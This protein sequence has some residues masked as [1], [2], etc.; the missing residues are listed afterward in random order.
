MKRLLVAVV[1]G[2]FATRLAGAQPADRD[3][4]KR[5]FQ[6]GEQAYAAGQYE[7]AIRAYE[8]AHQ[9]LPL[10]AITFSVAQAYRLAYYQ[11]RETE[12]LRKA[13]DLYQRYLDDAP[14]G[15]RRV[16]ATQ[17]LEA[18]DKILRAE[19]P[20]PGG[21]EGEVREPALAPQPATLLMVA[22]STSGA[23][24]RIDEGELTEVPFAV[25][26]TPGR[27]RV[28][29]QAPGHFAA[30]SQWL[31]VEGRL[32]VAPVQ[33]EAMP[34]RFVVRAPAGADVHLDGRWLGM[35]PLE[36]PIT[37]SPG[38]HTVSVSSRGRQTVRRAIEL[39]RGDTLDV[40]VDAPDLTDQRRAAHWVLGG[41]AVLAAAGTTTTVLAIT[42]ENR[43]KS[44]DERK[45]TERLTEDDRLS[46]EADLVLR[47]DLR[48]ASFV[49]FGGAVVAGAT[50]ALLFL[51]D[52]PRLDHEPVS[53][54]REGQRVQAIVAPGMLGAGWSWVH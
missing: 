27:H 39:G 16:H 53:G 46:R 34:A 35:A 7:L 51:I 32:V 9:R 8:E 6:A 10:P 17:H 40:T 26:V 31:A 13:R 45:G 1:V 19:E 50:G 43:V 44:Y 38:V 28:R 21:G 22:S 36:G 20:E 5:Y 4:A 25:P 24:A 23:R 52:T 54:S 41:A 2:L 47:N 14:T 29:V 15:N 18:I 30:E 33:L 3:E 49:L 11:D 48:T 37:A 42:A 12:K